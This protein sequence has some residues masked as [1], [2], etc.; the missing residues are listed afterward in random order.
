MAPALTAD[1]DHPSVAGYRRLGELLARRVDGPPLTSRRARIGSADETQYGRPRNAGA[2]SHSSGSPPP[3]PAAR[4]VGPACSTATRSR[5]APRRR[6]PAASRRKRR[7]RA[8]WSPMSRPPMSAR[9]PPA[10]ERAARA[11]HRPRA[12][13]R[14]RPRDP[15]ERHGRRRPSAADH[16]PDRR[17][18]RLLRRRRGRGRER[19]GRLR[20]DR[21]RRDDQRELD[22]DGVRRPG[23][24]ADEDRPPRGRGPGAQLLHP[25]SQHPAGLGDVPGRVRRQPADGRRD[26]AQR[27]AARRLGGPLR[28]RRHRHP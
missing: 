22:S 18:Q 10:R 6:P 7:R 16:R 21:H 14:L 13:P 26:R 4:M 28:P 15:G 9:S 19:R 5:S 2:R 1:G 3:R 23:G 20:P 25:R 8:W 12:D 11:G 27:I 24:D 17:P